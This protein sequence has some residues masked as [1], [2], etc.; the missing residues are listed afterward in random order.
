M[1]AFLRKI[2]FSLVNLGLDL[3]IQVTALLDMTNQWCLNIDKGMASGVIFL[4]LK[5]AVDTV[6]HATLRK[7]LCD[8]GVQGQTAFWFKCYLKDRQQFCVVN[9][10]SSVKNRIV[11]GVPQGFLLGPLLFLIYINDL[12]NCLD[13]SI[14]RSFADDTD[15]TFS[16]VDLSILQTEMSNDFNRI[17]NWLNILKTNFT[18]IGSRQRIATLAKSIHRTK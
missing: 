2:T 16:T 7:K 1:Y 12:P 15:L 13:D 4:D 3:F 18:V 17:F 10:L 8:Y 11:C 14:G 5:K 9:G 6:D